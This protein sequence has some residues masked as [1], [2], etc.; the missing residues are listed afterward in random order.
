MPVSQDPGQQN[1][2]PD[3]VPG[4]VQTTKHANP[5]VATLDSVLNPPAV[6]VES[7]HCLIEEEKGSLCALL[8]WT[9]GSWEENIIIL[10]LEICF[11]EIM[12]VF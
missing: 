1:L 7:S 6:S 5:E 3:P 4:L 8:I 10:K 11:E 9:G 2:E 12:F